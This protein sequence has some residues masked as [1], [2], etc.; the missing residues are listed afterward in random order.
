MIKRLLKRTFL[1]ILGAAA[2]A[3]A[4]DY[5]VLMHKSAHQGAFGSVEIHPY[6]AILQ[7][8]KTLDFEFLEPVNQ[9][10]VHSLFPHFGDAPCW[11]LERNKQKRIDI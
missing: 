7:K 4:A 8:N 11:Y 6:Y 2:L 1:T 5:A 3:Y 9:T 10:C